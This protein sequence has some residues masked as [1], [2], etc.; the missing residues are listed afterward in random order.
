MKLVNL[1]H[2][3]FGLVLATAL[4]VFNVY[5]LIDYQP[6]PANMPWS[7][8]FTAF[9]VWPN[10]AGLVMGLAMA[11]NF[12]ANTR[13]AFVA[14]DYV[15]KHGGGRE[16]VR[17]FYDLDHRSELSAEDLRCVIALELGVL[18]PYDQIRI[19]VAHQNNPVGMLIRCFKASALVKV[20]AD[21]KSFAPTLPKIMAIYAHVRPVGRFLAPKLEAAAQ[22]VNDEL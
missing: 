17:R 14:R 3:I 11:I 21:G 12:A 13:D 20:D 22:L 5:G 16:L 1:S 8:P 15:L 19:A 9:G 18:L 7:S 6:E 4:L 2:S 10:V